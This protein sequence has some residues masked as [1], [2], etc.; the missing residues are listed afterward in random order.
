M[1][2]RAAPVGGRRER[3]SAAHRRLGRRGPAG[4]HRRGAA[5]AD[6]GRPDR[7]EQR[8]PPAAPGDGRLVRAVVL[9]VTATVSPP[10]REEWIG[11]LEALLGDDEPDRGPARAAGCS[12][13]IHLDRA[14]RRRAQRGRA[15]AQM[16]PVADVL[17]A[18]PWLGV[19]ERDRRA[20]GLL[21]LGAGLRPGLCAAGRVRPAGR[22][23]AMGAAGLGRQPRTGRGRRV[24][25]GWPT[26]QRWQLCA[27]GG[28]TCWTTGMSGTST[29]GRRWLGRARTS[30]RTIDRPLLKWYAARYYSRGFTVSSRPFAMSSLT[31]LGL[32]SRRV[33]NRCWSTLNYRDVIRAGRAALMVCG[34]DNNGTAAVA[35]IED[36]AECTARVDAQVRAVLQTVMA[37]RRSAR[38]RWTT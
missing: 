7:P 30:A 33:T 13:G 4:R 25:S 6:R 8:L 24:R 11:A 34:P 28:S 18:H 29:S 32:R 26:S 31:T 15:S 10:T 2:A 20:G 23:P 1:G 16:K 12:P 14:G 17:A 19:C 5:R 27:S 38:R 35:S 9:A 36:V 21:P 3:R 22:E 37:Q